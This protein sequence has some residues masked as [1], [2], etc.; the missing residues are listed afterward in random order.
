MSV[1]NNKKVAGTVI[2]HLEDGGKK[3]L[4]KKSEEGLKFS[5][6]SLS[7]EQ[8]GL[9]CVLNTL[10]EQVNLDITTI[11]LVELTSGYENDNKIPLFV[12]EMK[13]TDAFAQLPND[14]YWEEP[15]AFFKVIQDFK[16]EGM[17]FF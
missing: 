12:F 17:P 8:T 16:I 6:S 5:S 1:L 13:E 10:K 2:L 15:K 14:F 3:F 4:L 7:E 9:A 11:H